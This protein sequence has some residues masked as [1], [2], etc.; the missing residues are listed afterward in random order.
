MNG[1]CSKGADC[2]FAHK[3][4]E[5]R[6]LNRQLCEVPKKRGPE[7]GF[8]FDGEELRCSWFNAHGA[9]FNFT[10]LPQGCSAGSLTEGS[11]ASTAS[12]FHDACSHGRSAK[13]MPT[14][15]FMVAPKEV[16]TD[17]YA[18]PNRDG[19]K[20]ACLWR[21]A[22]DG[23]KAYNTVAMNPAE[24]SQGWPDQKKLGDEI[25]KSELLSSFPGL[26]LDIKKPCHS[27]QPSACS[28]AFMVEPVTGLK[29]RERNTFLFFEDSEPNIRIRRSFSEGRL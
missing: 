23:S 10:N 13:A 19:A 14:S 2:T 12:E 27:W 20:N 4:K 26:V 18:Y 5:R 21:A 8:Q 17:G 9:N 25:A 16:N 3:S 15:S 7:N 29:Y 22:V 28:K 6:V 24:Q 11:E 1:S